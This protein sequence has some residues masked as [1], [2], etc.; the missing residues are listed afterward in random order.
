MY[1]SAYVTKNQFQSSPSL[2]I[3][4]PRFCEKRIAK[5]YFK[6]VLKGGEVAYAAPFKILR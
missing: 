3:L 4:I 2:I 1:C 5:I 6:E